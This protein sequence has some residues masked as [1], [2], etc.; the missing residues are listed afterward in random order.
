MVLTHEKSLGTAGTMV[1]VIIN[2]AQRSRGGNFRSTCCSTPASLPTLGK[3]SNP[4]C[5]SF[6]ILKAGNDSASLWDVERIK[7]ENAGK[8]L[9]TMP[10]TLQVFSRWYLTTVVAVAAFINH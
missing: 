1:D 9:S 6:L 4:L 3:S 8:Q 5:L 7:G 2:S 10:S